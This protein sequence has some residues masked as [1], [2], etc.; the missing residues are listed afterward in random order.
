AGR[1][2]VDG[3]S[4]CAHVRQRESADGHDCRRRHRGGRHGAGDGGESRRV[5][6]Q[7]PAFTITAPSYALTVTKKGPGQVTSTPGG[8]NC[9]SDCS[10]SYAPGTVVT[11]TATP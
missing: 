7:R 9:G 6:V 11:L 2:G 4:A 10:E 3:H 8:I 1:V 5:R